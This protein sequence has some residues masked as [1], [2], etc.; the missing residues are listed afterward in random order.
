MVLVST[1]ASFE[2]I[3]ITCDA[4]GYERKKRVNSDRDMRSKAH[5]CRS[6]RLAAQALNCSHEAGGGVHVV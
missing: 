2:L 3:I 6:D 5:V 1:M 4:V